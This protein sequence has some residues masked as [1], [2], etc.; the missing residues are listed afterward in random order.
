M[1]KESQEKGNLE[2][3][4]IAL[5]RKPEAPRQELEDRNARLEA[6]ARQL[7]EILKIN[8]ILRLDL[9][10]D[11][12]LDKVAKAIQRSLGFHRVLISL[13]DRKGHVF[14][15]K[16]QAGLSIEEF[17]RA[18]EQHIP[19]N[20]LFQFFQ[21]KFKISN[22]FFVS[23]REGVATEYDLK[24]DQESAGDG[25]WHPDNYLFIPLSGAD[26]KLLGVMSVDS[27]YDGQ[28]PDVQTVGILEMFA[29]QAAQAISNMMLYQQARVKAR[30]LETLSD[31]SKQIGTYLEFDLLLSRMVEIIK[32]HF[33][34][35]Q[36]AVLLWDEEQKKWMVGAPEEESRT[37]LSELTKVDRDLQQTTSQGKPVF[38]RRLEA[39][40]KR[41]RPFKGPRFTVH[42]PLKIRDRLVGLLIV[43]SDREEVFGWQDDLFWSSL[44]EQMAIAIGNA[45]LYQNARNHSI[46]D[47]LT[48]LFNHQYFQQQLRAE[49]SRSQRHGRPFSAIMLDIDHFKHYNDV[50]GHPTG[51]RVLKIIAQII[52]AE[53]RD[54]DILARYGGEEFAIILTE[55]DK[56]GAWKVAERIRT[57][58]GDHKFPHGQ[59][60]P[61]KKL[62]VSIGVASYP[63]DADN[64]KDLVERADE[65]LYMA[66]KAGRNQVF[67]AGQSDEVW[68]G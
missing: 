55:T 13:Y 42:I 10:L 30:A 44:S 6:R 16:A 39:K 47:G 33:G 50:C 29:N 23:H 41:E 1:S 38:S 53:V 26:G 35:Q 3:K 67:V 28:V 45:K 61:R 7:M 49:E 48:G 22:S 19:E 12:L 51:D 5:P 54:I 34:C 57:K 14:V 40:G 46:T 56:K 24:S 9:E 58:I 31:I 43:V 36:V 15:R 25:G 21:E 68:L 8:E 59:V 18:Q 60:Q 62:T 17:R 27:P 20:K 37:L 2:K 66:K 52:K 63:E 11:D 4:R 64:G 32:T 65:S